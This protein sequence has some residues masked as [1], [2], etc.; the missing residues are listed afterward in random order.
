[1]KQK[2]YW[3]SGGLWVGM[4]YALLFMVYL[5][6]VYFT[7]GN[8]GAGSGPGFGLALI[9]LA[10][11]GVPMVLLLDFFSSNIFDSNIILSIFML[12]IFCV[13]QWFIIGA[14]IG[15]IYGKIKSNKLEP[16]A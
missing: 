4:I 12:F 2:R 14:I 7:E 8:F 10:L 6:F 3:L 11:S 15:G 5:I 9:P 16:S 1:M 13:L